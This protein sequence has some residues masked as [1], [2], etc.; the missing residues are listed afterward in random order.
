MNYA[1]IKQQLREAAGLIDAGDLRGADELIRSCCGKGMTPND[2]LA[3]LGESR[4]RQ[5]R[6]YAKNEMDTEVRS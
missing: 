2:L 4:V 3:N 5:M 6:T 1:E